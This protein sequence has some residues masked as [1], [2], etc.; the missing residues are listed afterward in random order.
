MV[1]PLSPKGKHF[2]GGPECITRMAL[3]TGLETFLFLLFFSASKVSPWDWECRAISNSLEIIGLPRWEGGSKSSPPQPYLNF[4]PMFHE[5]DQTVKS[6]PAMQETQAHSL[7][8]KIPWRREWLLTSVFLPRES[9]G[10]RSLVGYSLWGHKELDMTEWLTLSFFMRQKI[11]C[12]TFMKRRR[13][14][15]KRER[16][17]TSKKE[18][19]GS[20]YVGC[21]IDWIPQMS[22]KEGPQHPSSRRNGQGCLKTQAEIKQ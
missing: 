17:K 22:P 8:G 2:T 13:S 4:A 19:P 18:I 14:T 12:P 6:P 9:H 3:L 15:R 5:T 16:I 20:W 21:I 11:M 1:S 7:V 10:Q